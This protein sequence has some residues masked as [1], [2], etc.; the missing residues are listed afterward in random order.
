[1]KI[2]LMRYLFYN[3]TWI[4]LLKILYYVITKSWEYELHSE[5]I[6]NFG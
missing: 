4:G 3:K 6:R 1:M 2:S 5:K